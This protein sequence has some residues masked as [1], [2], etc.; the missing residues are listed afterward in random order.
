MGDE[1][2]PI[3]GRVS[4]VVLGLATRVR[5]RPLM[6]RY[7]SIVVLGA[8]AL[9]NGFL[10]IALMSLLAVATGQPF[11]FPSLGP[12]AFLLFSSPLTPAASPRNTFLGHLV[13]VAAGWAALWVFGLLDAGPALVTGV[14]AARAGAAGL[15]LGL[16]AGLMVWLGVPHPPA[17]ATTLIVSLGI[18]ARPDQLV[19]LM[20]GVVVLVGQ[21]IVIN[22][23]A[24]LEYPLWAPRPEPG[25]GPGPRERDAGS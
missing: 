18:L 2:H 3:G 10:S 12:T 19:V 16:T 6:D 1:R 9:L 11:I 23:L 15:S 25:A 20:L 13:G 21:G 17:G 7:N 22:R 24:G 4:D 14:D 5:L 8:F